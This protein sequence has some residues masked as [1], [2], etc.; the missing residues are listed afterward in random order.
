MTLVYLYM[1][2]YISNTSQFYQ[3][4]FELLSFE[5]IASFDMM[6]SSRLQ[7]FEKKV[8]SPQK[9]EGSL[10]LSSPKKES[11][12]QRTK[13]YLLFFLSSFPPPS[14]PQKV[15]KKTTTSRISFQVLSRISVFCFVSLDK[16]QINQLFCPPPPLAFSPN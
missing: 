7:E 14:S 13:F 15:R 10:S 2:K 3:N 9:G 5:D 8:S 6:L 12:L 11:R 4:L 1:S 16:H